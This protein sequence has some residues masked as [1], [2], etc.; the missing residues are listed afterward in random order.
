[1]PKQRHLQNIFILG[2]F[3]II[4]DF[5]LSIW[6]QEHAIGVVEELQAED[7]DALL[8]HLGIDKYLLSK[9]CLVSDNNWD[10]D[11]KITQ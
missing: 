9:P 1:M 3:L 5:T 2:F 7:A 4:L 10:I 11:S 8:K 6:L